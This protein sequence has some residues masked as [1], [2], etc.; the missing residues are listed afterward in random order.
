[1]VIRLMQRY[2]QLVHLQRTIPIIGKMNA[3]DEETAGERLIRSLWSLFLRRHPRLVHMLVLIV[4]QGPVL[5]PHS[6]NVEGFCDSSL[7]DLRS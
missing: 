2:S 7:R 4:P 3:R 1:M 5:R 6:G